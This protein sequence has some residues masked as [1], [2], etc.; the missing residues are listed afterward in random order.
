MGLNF[1]TDLNGITV[2][3]ISSGFI[4]TLDGPLYK[5]IGD[6]ISRGKNTKDFYYQLKNLLTSL[7]ELDN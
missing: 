6:N 2:K 1:E 4:I 3:N 5:K 7:K